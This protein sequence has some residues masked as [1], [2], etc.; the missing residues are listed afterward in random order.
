MINCDFFKIN[1]ACIGFIAKSGTG[2]TSLL[3]K[4]IRQFYSMGIRVAVVKHTHHDFEIDTPG[5]DSYKL[6]HAGA[7]QTLIT[8]PNRW[9]LI[10]E[11]NARAETDTPLADSE[12]ML[13]KAIQQLAHNELD[14]VLIEGSKG[15]N[16]PKIELH[17]SEL[18]QTYLFPSDNSIVAIATNNPSL[19]DCSLPILD[20]N[21]TY[22]VCQFIIKTFNIKASFQP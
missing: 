21:D 8:G 7:Q 1:T 15:V 2:K 11:N 19:P 10:N 12:V 13:H 9:A 14:C 20:I 6:R 4:I 16:Y 5:K 18:Q 22:N 17:R 3:E